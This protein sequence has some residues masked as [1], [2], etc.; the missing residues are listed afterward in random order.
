M[1]RNL[2]K[3]QSKPGVSERMPMNG[4]DKVLELSCFNRYELAGKYTEDKIV[5]DAACADG[6][7]SKFLKAKKY[8]GLDY[9]KEAL[10]KAK[11]ECVGEFKKV[12]LDKIEIPDCDVL[13]CFETLEHLEDPI[14]FLERNKNKV[15]EKI[16]ISVPNNEEP[17]ANQFHKWIF[18]ENSFKDK[19]NGIF[20][21]VEYYQQDDKIIGEN[22][23]P[24][25][26][27]AVI[28]L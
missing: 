12:D 9:C 19:I 23:Y 14:G 4:E 15:K 25:W 5:V 2:I 1:K 26:L 17:G 27:I 6:Y 18:D 16:I 7:G 21:N 10:D 3:K 22:I 8:I 11:K 20:D 13:V 24:L 28:S